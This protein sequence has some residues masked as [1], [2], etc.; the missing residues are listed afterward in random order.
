MK[1]LIVSFM[2]WA[3]RPALR[4]LMEEHYNHSEF[5]DSEKQIFKNFAGTGSVEVS[6]EHLEQWK[7]QYEKLNDLVSR[8]ERPQVK[9]TVRS[10]E[11]YTDEANILLEIGLIDPSSSRVAIYPLDPVLIEA[12]RSEITS[13]REMKR[14]Y[15]CFQSL[16]GCHVEKQ[17]QQQIHS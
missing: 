8:Q 10:N 17:D 11:D 9:K 1:N 15:E 12:V 5:T 16:L 2:A 13:L 7:Q 3:I 14:R 4:K 6:P